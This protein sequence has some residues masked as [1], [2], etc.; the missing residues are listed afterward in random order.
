MD[1]CDYVRQYRLYLQALSRWLGGRG[2][3]EFTRDFGGVFYLFLR[4]MNER[5]EGSG[6]FFHKPIAEDMSLEMVLAGI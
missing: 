2:G 3:F 4:G 5:E 6:V 1:D